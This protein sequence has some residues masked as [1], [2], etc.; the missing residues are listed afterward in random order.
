MMGSCLLLLNPLGSAT[1]RHRALQ[2]CLVGTCRLEPIDRY[3]ID[4][5][6]FARIRGV[7]V[8]TLPIAP[9]TEI[10]WAYESRVMVVWQPRLRPRPGSRCSGN[11][12]WAHGPRNWG[13]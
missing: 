12:Q 1:T 6:K 7:A 11:L 13:H 2:A 5:K 3:S 9:V 4:E 10:R 8:A